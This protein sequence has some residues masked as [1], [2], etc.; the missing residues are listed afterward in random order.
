[1]RFLALGACYTRS[2]AEGAERPFGGLWCRSYLSAFAW[3]IY[4]PSSWGFGLADSEPL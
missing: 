3:L 4:C 2:R 1:M